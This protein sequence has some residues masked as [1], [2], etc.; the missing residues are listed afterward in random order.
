M[1]I[2]REKARSIV[3]IPKS[4]E[5]EIAAHYKAEFERM[6]KMR[7]NGVTGRIEFDNYV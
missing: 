4:E 3:K 2:V 5:K 1:E 7:A 6:Q